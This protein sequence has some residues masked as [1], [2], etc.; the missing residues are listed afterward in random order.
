MRRVDSYEPADMAQ[1][2]AHPRQAQDFAA[3]GDA[4][5]AAKLL[6]KAGSAHTL[7]ADGKVLAICGVATVD[8]GYG[9]GWLFMSADAG[10]Y[11]RW[12]TRVVRTYLDRQMQ[13]RR[14]IDCLVRADWTAAMRWAEW[15]GFVDEGVMA[16]V[17]WDGGDMHRFARVRRDNVQVTA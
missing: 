17:A 16:C 7:R 15:L 8:A 13:R 1:L 12:I 3:L 4:Q 9:H 10:P 6:A 11:M 14:R 5:A 2:R